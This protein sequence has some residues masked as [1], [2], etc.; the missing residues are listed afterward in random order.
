MKNMINEIK[1]AINENGFD[2]Q[3]EIEY[4]AKYC[5][6]FVDVRLYH[7]EGYEIQNIYDALIMSSALPGADDM[8]IEIPTSEEVRF[9]FSGVPFERIVINGDYEGSESFCIVGGNL[10]DDL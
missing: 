9:G 3:F 10:L 4:D 8:Q 7:V 5:P 1:N 2:G 6:E